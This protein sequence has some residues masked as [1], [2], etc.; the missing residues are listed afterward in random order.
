MSNFKSHAREG[1]GAGNGHNEKWRNSPLWDSI[2]AKGGAKKEP[3]EAPKVDVVEEELT[4]KE[5]MRRAMMLAY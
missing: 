2:E 3:E 1:R 4:E 5:R